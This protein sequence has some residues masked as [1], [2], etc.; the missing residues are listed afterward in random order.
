M[1]ILECTVKAD[2]MTAWWIP[3]PVCVFLLSISTSRQHCSAM[4]QGHPR[5]EHV[6]A[7]SIKIHHSLSVHIFAGVV[8]NNQG[9]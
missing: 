6:F 2:S 3:A 7:F 1:V 5:S 8:F 9:T 4:R